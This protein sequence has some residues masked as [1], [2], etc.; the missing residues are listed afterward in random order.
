MKH[1]KDA[2]ENADKII[3]LH[4]LN[5]LEWLTAV[6]AAAVTVKFALDLGVY[7]GY[8]PLAQR[9]LNYLESL[10]TRTSND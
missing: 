1:K 7:P 8:R 9:T 5:G 3:A 6:R 2:V 10:T 4:R